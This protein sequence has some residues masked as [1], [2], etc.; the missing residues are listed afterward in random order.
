MQMSFLIYQPKPAVGWLYQNAP[1]VVQIVSLPLASQVHWDRGFSLGFP[2]EHSHCFSFVLLFL[3]VQ[4]GT[5][6]CSLFVMKS[7]YFFL[8]AIPAMC[9]ICS[10]SSHTTTCS[11]TLTNCRRCGHV[12]RAWSKLGLSTQPSHLLRKKAPFQ[13]RNTTSSFLVP[14]GKNKCW[15][16]VNLLSLYIQGEVPAV[17]H[18]RTRHL[19]VQLCSLMAQLY[20]KKPASPTNLFLLPK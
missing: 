20:K 18:L 10:L 14:S 3:R 1:V 5:L 17:L 15:S 8:R 9:C 16:R 11:P 6:R 7:V 13:S 19:Y 12:F 4:K 2:L